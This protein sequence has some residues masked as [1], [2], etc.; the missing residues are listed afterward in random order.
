[1]QVGSD[2]DG[3]G[4]DGDRKPSPPAEIGT[5][6]MGADPT[7]PAGVGAAVFLNFGIGIAGGLAFLLMVFGAYRLIFAAG[8]P[9]AVQPAYLL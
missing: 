8:N 4:D 3:D 6:S 2:D 7:T 1:M 9:E 5:P